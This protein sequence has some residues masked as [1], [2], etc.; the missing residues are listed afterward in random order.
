MF[1]VL[2]DGP[3]PE[4]E[5]WGILMSWRCRGAEHPGAE[6]SVAPG[7][8]PLCR[9]FLVRIFASP[10][11][12]LTVFYFMLQWF[13]DLLHLS[14]CKL[15]QTFSGNKSLSSPSLCGPV[16]G[17]AVT[18]TEHLRKDNAS[19]WGGLV[20]TSLLGASPCSSGKRNSY[21]R[22]WQKWEIQ[23]LSCQ[24]GITTGSLDV[25]VLLSGLG[26]V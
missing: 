9:G 7:V 8:F 23:V 16:G 5:G 18:G 1:P 21:P 15:P 17:L 14:W 11:Y 2:V 3:F 10:P 24:P 19:F 13:F 22:A 6:L 25:P 12:S 26:L 20:V 4:N